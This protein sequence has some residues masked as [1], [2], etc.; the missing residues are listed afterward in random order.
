MPKRQKKK[1]PETI[2]EFKKEVDMLNRK[3]D[4]FTQI[5][6]ELQHKYRECYDIV[7][8]NNPNFKTNLDSMVWRYKQMEKDN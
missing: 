1:Q 8:A 6:T 3:L 5:I 4:T 7:I 2:N